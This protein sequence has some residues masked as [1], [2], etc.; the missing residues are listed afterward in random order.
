MAPLIC[1]NFLNCNSN[2]LSKEYFALCSCSCFY[3]LK[4]FR[5]IHSLP[6]SVSAAKSQ[7]HTF[8]SDC[9]VYEHWT[10]NYCVQHL[11]RHSLTHL[12][13]A[14]V[15]RPDLTAF[16]SWAPSYIS[17]LF[18]PLLSTA[19]LLLSS[20][21]RNDVYVPRWSV[22]TP[23]RAFRVTDHLAAMHCL[24]LFHS[25]FLFPSLFNAKVSLLLIHSKAVSAS[26]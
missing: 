8:V 14:G 24:P 15:Q 1:C 22:F 11:G 3:Q 19:S 4:L 17:G 2:L 21:D 9:I 23:C 25:H 18:A 26:A 13:T 12:D 20:I 6:P 7:V 5:T 16:R 10:G